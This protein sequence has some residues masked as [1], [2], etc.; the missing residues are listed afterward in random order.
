MKYPHLQVDSILAGLQDRVVESAQWFALGYFGRSWTSLNA[1]MFSTIAED[2]VTPSWITP[3]DT[4]ADWDYNYG[5]NV[6]PLS[7][8]Y[9]KVQSKC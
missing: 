2:G 6:R 7:A 8:S 1:T 3:M 9:S 4:C 5:N